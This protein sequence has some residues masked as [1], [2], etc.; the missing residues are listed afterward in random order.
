MISQ[1]LDKLEKDV[2]SMIS[3]SSI[4]VTDAQNLLK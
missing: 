3:E 4:N 1:D 2:E